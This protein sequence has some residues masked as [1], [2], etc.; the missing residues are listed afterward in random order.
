MNNIMW[1]K[2]D[3]EVVGVLCDWDLAEDHSNGDCRAADIGLSDVA[4][5]PDKEQSKTTS[6]RQS[7]H[8]AIKPSNPQNIERTAATSEVQVQPRHRTGTGPF[9]AV[10]LLLSNPPPP[11]KYRH[12]L[13]S[14]LYIY[15]SAAVTFDPRRKQKIRA[16]EAWNSHDLRSIGAL[17]A[18]FLSDMAEYEETLQHAH[19]DF[20]PMVDGPLDELYRL[21]CRVE[22]LS[23]QARMMR[24]NR[25]VGGE[26]MDDLQRQRDAVA[27]YKNFMDILKEPEDSDCS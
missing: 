5:P 13:E 8:I 4:A 22:F 7:Q 2:R 18:R 14:F 20:K 24:I 25:H 6:Q 17:K 11:H 15:I 27:T 19:A 1:F 16:Y 23:Y 21:F 9:M 10:D 26:N 3:N 12:D